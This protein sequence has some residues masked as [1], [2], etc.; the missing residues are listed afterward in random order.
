MEAENIIQLV[1]KMRQAQRRY[2]RTH[3][4]LAMMSAKI[5]EKQVDD[6]ICEHEQTRDYS[7]K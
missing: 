1:K 4:T 3:S 7:S 5:F 2:G 6:M